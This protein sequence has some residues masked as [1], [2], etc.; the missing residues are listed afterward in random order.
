MDCLKKK[1]RYSRIAA[2]GR[3]NKQLS[4][5]KIE[6]VKRVWIINPNPL[7]ILGTLLYKGYQIFDTE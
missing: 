7:L 5:I 3:E 1:V 6:Y 4:I 2:F